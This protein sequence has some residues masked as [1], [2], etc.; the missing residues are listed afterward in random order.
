MQGIHSISDFHRLVHLPP[1][2]H[3]QVSMIRLEETRFFPEDDIWKRFFVNYYCV[4]LKRDV[5]G[6]LKYGQQ[7][8]DYDK[9][10]MSFTAP[11]QVQALD[12][13]NME[14]GKGYLLVFHPDFLIRHPL[15]STLKNAGMFSYAVNEA[16][17]LSAQE[18]QDVISIFEKIERECR[19]IDRHTQDIVLSQIDLMMSYANRF[20]E[21]QFFTRKP[22][23]H[24]LLTRFDQVVA[25]YFEQRKP[26]E[27]GILTVQYIAGRLNLSP[28]YLGDMLR[29]L[30]GQNTQQHIREKMIGLAKELL[31]STSLSVAEIAYRLGF[32]HPQSL[33]KLFKTHT[34]VSPLEFR[35]SFN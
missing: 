2:L 12:I 27:L 35:H 4:S 23:S 34:Q 32:E 20:Y 8:Y 5:I 11:R 21:R 7:Y 3:P 31:A 6:K 14:C 16:L 13:P 19:H 18:E 26:E 22:N 28:N 10:V 25:E 1:P 9:G 30:T 24:D 33:N 29:V 17:H 15:A